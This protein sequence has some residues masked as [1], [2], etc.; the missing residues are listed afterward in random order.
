MAIAILGPIGLSFQANV[1][2]TTRKWL[3]RGRQDMLALAAAQL[4]FQAQQGLFK[5]SKPIWVDI[6][7]GTGSN[8]EAMHTY[9][10]VP[11]FFSA[12]FLVD[13]SPSLCDVATKRFQ[14]LGWDVKVIC[15]DARTFRLEDH[16]ETLTGVRSTRT[17]LT[18]YHSADTNAVYRADLITMSYSL[19][20][21][22]DYYNVVDSMVRLLAPSGVLGAVD[23]YVQSI[24]ETTGRNYIGGSFNRHV[25]WLSR[26]FWRA[27]FDCDRV[28]LEGARRDYLEY[29]F[30]TK[31]ILDQRNYRLGGIPYYIFLGCH[32][33]G[34]YKRAQELLNSVD[35]SCTESPQ[36]IPAKGHELVLPLLPEPAIPV[37]TRSKAYN[38]AIVNLSSNLPLPSTFYQN[39]QARI[40]YDE[41]LKKH[42]QFNHDYLYAFTWEDP[43]VDQRLLQIEDNDTILCLTSGGDNLLEYLATTHPRR[44]H[45]VDLNPNQNH[46]LELKIAAFQ[47]LPYADVWKIFG[48]GQHP[49]FRKLLVI[50]LSP[51]MSS[52]AFQF[53]MKHTGRFK[54]STGFYDYGGSGHAIRLVRSLARLTGLKQEIEKFCSSKT[55]NEQREVWCK[56]RPM[57]L[58]R[59]LHWALVGTEWFLWKAAGVPP[60]QRQLIIRD[61]LDRP[62]EESAKHKRL[63]DTTGEAMWDYIVNTLDPVAKNTLLSEENYHYLLTLTGHYTRRCHPVYLSPKAYTKLSQ[64][65]AFSGLRIHTDELSEIIQ[66]FKPAT[67]TIAIIMD[68]MDWFDPSSTAAVIQVQ[69]LN[70]ALQPKG[71]VLLRSAGLKPWYVDEFEKHGFSTRRVAARLPGMCVDRVNMYASTWIMTKIEELP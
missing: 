56:I 3:L 44:T 37:E 5:Q 62:S 43:R 45:A 11:T 39:H 68:S 24:V 16:L 4:R 66:R 13:L 33:Q 9:L 32:C 14:R 41:Q 69:A 50:K 71:R 30:G 70:R 53:W 6:G 25:N 26:V 65:Q 55:R 38:S 10:D 58:S 59:T 52:Q 21:I 23:F 17:G 18:E 35:A 1:Y 60:P 64:P 7:G 15:E 42:T 20:M 49:D 27:W 31:K 12:V 61:A 51:H 28:S 67:L 2:D 40:Y 36:V 46:L 48:E 8:I 47:A 63:S 19:S 57:I 22:P 34:L 54:S 29:R